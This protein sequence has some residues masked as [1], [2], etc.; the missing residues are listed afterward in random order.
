MSEPLAGVPRLD[1]AIGAGLVLGYVCLKTVDRVGLYGF[2]DRVRLYVA[3]GGGVRSFARLQRRSAQLDY[4]RTETNFTLGIAELSARLSRRSL[5]VLLTEFVDTVT[6]ELMIENVQRLARR[7]LVL[8][9]ALHDPWLEAVAA[10]E[11]ATVDELHRAVVA[12]DFVRERELVLGRLRQLGVH[13]VDAPPG[14]VSAQ[15]LDR[16]LE[17]RRRELV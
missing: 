13:C 8:F 7:H 11:P 17:I 14:R 3:P 16:Y 2:D 10:R 12:G 1:H 9:V 15:L 4:G 6:A 5:V